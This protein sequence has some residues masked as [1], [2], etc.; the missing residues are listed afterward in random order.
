MAVKP[1]PDCRTCGACCVGGYDDGA[2]FADVLPVD[3]ARMSRHVR[4]QLVR[5]PRFGVAD[6]SQSLATQYVMTE[7]LGAVCRYLAG[8][9]GSR[10]SCR[11]YET[12]PRA[13]SS[14]TPGGKSCREARRELGL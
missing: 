7:E 9:P 13:C 5:G 6:D 14:F 11:I 4:L 10:V 8:T 12:R 1:A 2:G 3:A